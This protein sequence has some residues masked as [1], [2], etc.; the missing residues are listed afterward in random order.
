MLNLDFPNLDSAV[1]N[2]PANAGDLASIPGS[3][4]SSGEGNGNPLQHSCLE[5]LADGGA[6]WAI[7]YGVAK[8][9]TRLRDLT[10]TSQTFASA[11]CVRNLKI[12]NDENWL[13][14]KKSITAKVISNQ[15]VLWYFYLIFCIFN[16]VILMCVCIYIKLFDTLKFLFFLNDQP[17]KSF[18]L[19]YYYYILN[20]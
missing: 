7:V 4:R 2:P 19:L 16:H 17:C 15:Y 20:S 9:Q 11:I 10:F 13:L 12:I 18:I 14:K 6:W 5:N 1:K 3:G 8:S